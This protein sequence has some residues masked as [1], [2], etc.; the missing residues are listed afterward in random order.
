[1]KQ[2]F[3]PILQVLIVC[4]LIACKESTNVAFIRLNVIL[5]NY[6]GIKEV[7]KIHNEKVNSYRVTLDSVRVQYQNLSNQNG[8]ET[9]LR[10]LEQ[11]MVAM[12]IWLD[13]NSDILTNPL[14]GGTL[15]QI[16]SFVAEYARTNNISIVLGSNTMGNVMYGDERL[17]ITEEVLQGLNKE[18]R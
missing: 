18:Y 16:N 1:M 10:Q 12:Q 2:F 13:A 5:E 15:E 14:F 7:R 4:C 3:N 9:D 11:Q 6:D 17:D 8:S